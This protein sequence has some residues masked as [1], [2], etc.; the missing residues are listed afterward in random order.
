MTVLTLLQAYSFDTSSTVTDD[1]ILQIREV[2]SDAIRALYEKTHKSI[3]GF[4]LSITKNTHDA[5]DTLSETFLAVCRSAEG[6]RPEGKPMAWLLT[7]AKNIA[8]GK[9]RSR[10]ADLSLDENLQENEEAFLRIDN[11][12][13]RLTLQA[14]LTVLSDKER[15]IV[16]LHAVAGLKNREIASLLALPL[17]TVLAK[18][19]RALKKLKN[20]L[21]GGSTGEKTN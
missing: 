19:H 20:H 17:G 21:E 2:G 15:R 16:V 14:A 11:T 4:A 5:E 10:K 1:D 6:Y 12:E 9:L 7:I 8:N 18:Y 3:Y 13:E